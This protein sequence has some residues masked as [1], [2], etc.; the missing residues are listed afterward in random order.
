MSWL[1]EAGHLLKQYSSGGA[2]ATGTAPDVHAHFDQVVQVVP[3]RNVAESLAAAFRSDRTPPFGQMLS[4]LFTNSNAD[5]KAGMLNQLISSVNPTLLSQI[6]SGA[7]LAGVAEGAG[8][9]LTP[10]QA[11]KLSPDVVQQMAGDAEKTNPSIIDSVSG[12]Y[13]QHPT[14]IKGLGGAA[15][16]VALA[17]LAER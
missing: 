5:Q 17:K 10:D 8:A 9:Q 3:C 2:A 6:L 11:Q 4:T 14:L 13:A 16:T 7:G 12:F 1:N 15:L